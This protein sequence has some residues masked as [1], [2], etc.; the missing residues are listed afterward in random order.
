MQVGRITG[1]DAAYPLYMDTD[2][3]GHLAASDAN[4]VD[5]IHTDGGRLGFPIPLGHADFYPNG[6]RG[7]QPGCD[8]PNI[9]SMGMNSLLNRIS[10]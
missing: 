10:K 1:L 4:F 6:G 3:S 7:R 2:M 5:V 9:L 8:I